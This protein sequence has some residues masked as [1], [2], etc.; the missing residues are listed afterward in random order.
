MNETTHENGKKRKF[1]ICT[2][3]YFNYN[4]NLT[5]EVFNF[6]LIIFSVDD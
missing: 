2:S 5:L 6:P 3:N 4:N 1:A